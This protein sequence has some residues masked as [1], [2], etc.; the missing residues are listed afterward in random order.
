M[1][2]LGLAAALLLAATAAADEPIRISCHEQPSPTLAADHS[3]IALSGTCETVVISGSGNTIKGA[4]GA[5]T[6]TVSGSDNTIWI[7]D[8]D[9]L[10][11]SGDRNTIEFSDGHTTKTPE[12]SDSGKGNQI[13]KRRH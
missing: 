1:T 12:V 10:S 11:V 3:T 4:W 2:R 8:L 6:L 9:K 5:T 7:H 13:T